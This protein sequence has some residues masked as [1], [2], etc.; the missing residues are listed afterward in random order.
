[1]VEACTPTAIKVGDWV[2][3]P[4]SSTLSG[5]VVTLCGPLGPKGAEIYGVLLRRKPRR[6]YIEVR[7][8]QIR[9]APVPAVVPT[10]TDAPAN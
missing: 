6:A 7:G 9:V 8:D 10:Q 5:K 1:M 2:Q 4:L 3:F